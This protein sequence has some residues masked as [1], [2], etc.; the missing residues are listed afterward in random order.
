[1]NVL[2][3]Y[4]FGI[5]DIICVYLNMNFNELMV[6]FCMWLKIWVVFFKLNY[7]VMYFNVLYKVFYIVNEI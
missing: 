1:M 5:S 4:L 6:E 2:V 7:Y 3:V